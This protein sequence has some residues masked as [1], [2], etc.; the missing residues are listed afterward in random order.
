MYHAADVI[1]DGIGFGVHGKLRGGLAIT[2]NLV[3]VFIHDSDHILSKK[4]LILGGG[5]DVDFT[6]YLCGNVALEGVDQRFLVQAFCYRHDFA[7]DVHVDVHCDSSIFFNCLRP[8][9]RFI[10]IGFPFMKSKTGFSCD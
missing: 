10:K 3:A 4:A 9:G 2:M 6:V 8:G 7:D 5:G 1:A